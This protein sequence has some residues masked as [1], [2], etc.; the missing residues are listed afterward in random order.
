MLLCCPIGIRDKHHESEEANLTR[1]HL[2]FLKVSTPIRRTQ[3]RGGQG[4]R[5]LVRPMI[6]RVSRITMQVEDSC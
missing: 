6:K 4:E 1:T 5:D 2:P 3:H